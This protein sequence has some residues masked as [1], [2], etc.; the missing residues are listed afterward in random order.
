MRE[1]HRI[2]YIRVDRMGD[3]LMNLPAIRLLRQT[4]P[5]SWLTVLMDHS[6]ADL[7]KGHPDIDEVMTVESVKF[8]ASTRYR[9]RFLGRL[10]EMGFDLAI[11][12]HPDKH[13]HLL[14]FLAGIGHRVGY[15]RKLG[16]FLTKKMADAKGQSGCHEIDLNLELVSL[17]SDRTWDGELSLPVD[18]LAVRE[19]Q[20]LFEKSCPGSRSWVALHA[21]TSNPN[22]RWPV[23]RFAELCDRIQER[24]PWRAVLVGDAQA[25]GA[26]AEVLAKA[27]LS[28]LDW[29][30]VLSIKQ[31]VAFF[32]EP[33]VRALVSSDSGPVHIA[34]IS[35][36]PVV[37]LYAK[38]QLG[39][40]PAR[41]GPRDK[42]SR[43]IHKPMLEITPAEVYERLLEVLGE[44]S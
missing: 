28:V 6:V 32:H 25:K 23:E 11:V 42:A 2:L 9:W 4:Y 8:K 20:T 21:G 19:V 36:K 18:E 15:N 14:T 26:S 3:V 5:K 30:G 31:L 34:W 17:V 13:W 10:R 1:I 37:A 33:R 24:N 7:L 27:R 44:H 41:W 12:P 43:V 38:N 39:S 35:G 29:T 22:K 16:F 40:D